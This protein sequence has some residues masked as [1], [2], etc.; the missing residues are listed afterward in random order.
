LAHSIAKSGIK[1]EKN[2]LGHMEMMHKNNKSM[3]SST[4]DPKKGTLYRMGLPVFFWGKQKKERGQTA[5]ACPL[6]TIQGIF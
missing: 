1:R 5:W 3:D 2:E 4:K 6:F